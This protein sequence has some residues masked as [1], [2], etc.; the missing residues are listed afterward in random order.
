MEEFKEQV[1]KVQVV[2]VTQKI[3]VNYIFV[4]VLAAFH[5]VMVVMDLD[6]LSGGLVVQKPLGHL[7]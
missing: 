1:F 6:N 4:L 7:V 5:L 2:D 3:I